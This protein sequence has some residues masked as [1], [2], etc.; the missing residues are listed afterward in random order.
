MILDLHVHSKH[1]FD[2]FLKPKD[3]I[4]AAKKK[5]LDGIAITDH[6]T[7]NGGLEARKLN[8]DPYFV[9]IIG[10][11]I[12]TEMGDIIG[13][14]LEKDIESRTGMEVIDEIHRQG[15]IAVLPHPYK[16][17]KLLNEEC[18]RK[19]DVIE[20]FNSRTSREN[21]RKA[22][23]LAERF[24]KPAIGGSDAH[25][26][27]EIGACKVILKSTDIRNEIMNGKIELK[28]VYTPLAMQSVSQM[29][30]SIKLKKYTELPALFT[31]LI[32]NIVRGK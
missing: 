7:I 2:S 32:I 19:I 28:T 27:S 26:C 30:K 21:N 1:S 23:D 11:E 14:F 17:H 4:C 6:N 22:R 8:P 5:G 13:L 20:C 25:F 16:G 18:I 24:K 29:V 31:R 3:I 12:S 15:G 9:V 10:A